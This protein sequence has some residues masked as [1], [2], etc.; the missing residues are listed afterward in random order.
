[1]RNA[2]TRRIAFSAIVLAT[3]TTVGAAAAA[4]TPGSRD[5]V[6]QI[7]KATEN[8]VWRLNTQTGEIA[9]CDLTGDN[10]VCTTTTDAA[11]APKKTFEQIEADRAAAEQAAKAEQD[12]RRDRDLKLL[13][14]ILTFFRE[15][16]R[17]ALGQNGSA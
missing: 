5:G 14:K 16:I 13:D 7:V 17:T 4:E 1:M 8:R 10:L 6:Y 11:I 9:V 3:L 12:A 15:L 2:W